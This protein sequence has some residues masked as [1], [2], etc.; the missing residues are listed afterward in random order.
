M[1]QKFHVNYR[2]GG[3]CNH[4]FGLLFLINHYVTKKTIEIPW[5]KTCTDLP[6]VWHVPSRGSN[7]TSEPVMGTV[8]VKSSTDMGN[9]KKA[10]VQCLLYE[11]RAEESKQFSEESVSLVKEKFASPKR[12]PASYLIDKGRADNIETPFGSVSHGSIL[13]YQLKDHKPRFKFTR[14]LPAIVLHCQNL[15]HAIELPRKPAKPLLD[16]TKTLTFLFHQKVDTI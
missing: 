5:D 2:A 8:F 10:P 7:I 9:R 6:Q 1:N 14:T 13:S 11:A 4:V 15:T 3:F 12:A 16:T